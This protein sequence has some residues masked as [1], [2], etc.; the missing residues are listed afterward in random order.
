MITGSVRTCVGCGGRAL[1]DTLIRIA[2]D[3]GDLLVDVRRRAPGR[4]AYL[5]PSETCWHAFARR[6][7]LVRSLGIAPAQGQR[8]ALTAALVAGAAGASR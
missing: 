4:G 6:R 8:E 7:G 1:R 2:V 3:E 5:H